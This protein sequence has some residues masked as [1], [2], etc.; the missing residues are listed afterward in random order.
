MMCIVHL[1][2]GDHQ[3]VVKMSNLLIRDQSSTRSL[4]KTALISLSICFWPSVVIFYV[5]TIFTECTSAVVFHLVV[6][7][8]GPLMIIV[9][10]RLFLIKHPIQLYL[11]FFSLFYNLH[12]TARHS[13]RL[14][15]FLILS[16]H[17]IMCLLLLLLITDFQKLL[18]F[19]FWSDLFMAKRLKIPNYS[20]TVKF[21]HFILKIS[22]LLIGYYLFKIVNHYE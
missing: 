5:C 8:Y 20:L 18:Y 12:Q 17:L 9:R 2:I 19:C 4:L 3:S 1:S 21:K 7:H 16:V 15:N 6:F 11:S 13:R 10:F 22:N 14:L